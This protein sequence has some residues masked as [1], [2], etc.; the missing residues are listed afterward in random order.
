[1]GGCVCVCVSAHLMYQQ[2]V[3]VVSVLH[4]FMHEQIFICIT[5]KSSVACRYCC[6][7]CCYQIHRRNKCK[8]AIVM[9]VATGRQNIFCIRLR[10]IK[11]KHTLIRVRDF[12]RFCIVE[13]IASY[14]HGAWEWKG[15]RIV[16]AWHVVQHKNLLP[17]HLCVYAWSSKYLMPIHIIVE[18]VLQSGWNQR[19]DNADANFINALY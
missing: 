8:R 9:V 11:P 15:C 17:S 4:N 13:R 14:T 12:L 1:M 19:R 5:L 7:C 3:C 18:N 2:R 6:C 16:G 10:E